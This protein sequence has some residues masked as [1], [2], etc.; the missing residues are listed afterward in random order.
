MNEIPLI[1][2]FFLHQLRFSLAIEDFFFI[3]SFALHEKR[4][5]STTVTLS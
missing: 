1:G 3:T 4:L 5:K 2:D